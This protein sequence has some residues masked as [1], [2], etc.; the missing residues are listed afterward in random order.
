MRSALLVGADS[1]L[2]AVKGLPQVEA[3]VVG[4]VAFGVYVIRGMV[5]MY[6]MSLVLTSRLSFLVRCRSIS[7]LR[8][9]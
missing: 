6:V 8:R 7:L 1:G 2:A 9:L 4:L 5:D 3:L